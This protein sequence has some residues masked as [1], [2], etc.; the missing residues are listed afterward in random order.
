MPLWKQRLFARLQDPE[1]G[2]GGGGAPEITPEVQ[3]I[4]DAKISEAV[5][6]LKSKNGELLGK[7]KDATTNLQRFDGID[8]DAVRTILSKFASDEEAALLAKGEIDTVLTK[9]TE[10]M[11]AD[12]AKVVKA[13]QEA[14]AKAEAKAGKL[15]AR[16]LAGAIRDAAIKA[17]ALPEA[18]EDIVLRGG[19]TWRLN[20]DGEPVAMNGDEVVLGK[21]GKTPLTP[22]EWAES[23]RETAPHLWP[24]AQGTNAPGAK[25]GGGAGNLNKKA[26]EMTAA[27]KSVYI[28]ANGLAKWNEKVRTDYS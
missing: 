10:R 18:M 22:A 17:G 5:T 12:N 4:I 7:L 25:T 27:E 1:P 6:G 11:Q 3:A 24:K 16:T 26:S 21:D 19:G 9:R 14:R 15:A 13:E 28:T 2:D 8:P 23:L 20:D